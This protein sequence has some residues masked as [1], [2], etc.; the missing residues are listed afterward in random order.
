MNF[1]Q[2]VELLIPGELALT[3][4][5]IQFLGQ[6]IQDL[7]RQIK[8]FLSPYVLIHSHQKIYFIWLQSCI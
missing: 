1:I 6:F 2:N 8:I 3:L 7:N 4:N 5:Q